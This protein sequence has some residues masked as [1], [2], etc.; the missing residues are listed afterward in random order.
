MKTYMS[1]IIIILFLFI[2]FSIMDFSNYVYSEELVDSGLSLAVVQSV[3]STSDKTLQIKLVLLNTSNANITVLTDRLDTEFL[4]D[5]NTYVIS[6]GSM[7]ARYQGYNIVESLYKFAPVTLKPKE[8]THVNH[9]VKRTFKD[10]NENTDFILRYEIRGK[11]GKRFNVWYGAVE[12]G[13][14]KPRIIK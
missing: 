14:I 7:T 3:Y 13:P 9:L 8:A 6:K 11:F 2:G 12:S 1:K 10:I 5:S 4:K